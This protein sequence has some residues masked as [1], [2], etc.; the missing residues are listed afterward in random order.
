MC[1][2]STPLVPA[3]CTVGVAIRPAC[4]AGSGTGRKPQDVEDLSSRNNSSCLFHS[5]GVSVREAVVEGLHQF[6]AHEERP[7]QAKD[8]AKLDGRRWGKVERSLA[9]EGEGQENGQGTGK[10]SPCQDIP[11]RAACLVEG[12]FSP[13]GEE[14][15]ELGQDATHEP[16]GL[17]GS[18]SLVHKDCE[19]HEVKN[20]A[21]HTEQGGDEHDLLNIVLSSACSV[22][23]AS[24]VSVAIEIMGKSESRFSSRIWSGSMG[25]KVIN[26]DDMAMA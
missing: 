26:S 1:P 24:T 8:N 23:A 15:H 14:K 18:C 16:V 6:S 3:D 17:Q 19:E 20:G 10:A 7:D 25:R 12:Q 2:L 11:R 4:A 9:E 22:P 21:H 5:S 13:D